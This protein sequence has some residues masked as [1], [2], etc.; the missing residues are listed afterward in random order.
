MEKTF[1][2]NP[3]QTELITCVEKIDAEWL[4]FHKTIVFS[5]S[6]G[7]ESDHGILSTRFQL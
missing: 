4:L 7:Q 5:F 1:W 3:Y 6:G 2:D